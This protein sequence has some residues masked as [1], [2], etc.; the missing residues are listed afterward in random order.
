MNSALP[1][2]HVFDPAG[3]LGAWRF[4]E[5]L[6]KS[7]R[8][9][10]GHDATLT[11]EGAS[12]PAYAEHYFSPSSNGAYK[13]SVQETVSMTLAVV[14]RPNVFASNGNRFGISNFD[15]ANQ[16]G[17][18]VYLADNAT[19][20]LIKWLG[21]SYVDNA[22]VKENVST[23]E[24]SAAYS[25]RANFRYIVVV[26]DAANNQMRLY[27]PHKGAAPVVYTPSGGRKIA[28]RTLAA[29]D[30]GLMR[31]GKSISGTSFIVD[32]G[33]ASIYG[34]AKS[35]EQVMAM[36]AKSKKFWKNIRGIDLAA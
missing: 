26:I 19:T 18:S 8:D 12:P 16:R 14:M 23:P 4:G 32:I 9:L 24:N 22:G 13:T 29:D 28:D 34:V 35:T 31:I 20:T 25:T 15:T 30:G 1:A 27:A 10:S 11:L 21:Q 36:Y 6:E 17:S 3:L 7:A 33:E 5:K 2:A